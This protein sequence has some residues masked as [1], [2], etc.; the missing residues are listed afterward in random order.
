MRD[1]Q[2]SH[3]AGILSVILFKRTTLYKSDQKE[4]E[5]ISHLQNNYACNTMH[6]IPAHCGMDVIVTEEKG[7]LLWNEDIDTEVDGA[8]QENSL[9]NASFSTILTNTCL[10][11]RP[12]FF[13]T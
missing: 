8:A 7:T 2:Q 4:E 6:A 3:T 9:S 1:S 10:A 12:I 13:R 11:P 5:S